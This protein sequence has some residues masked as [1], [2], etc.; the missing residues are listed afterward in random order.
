MRLPAFRRDR[1]RRSIFPFEDLFEDIFGGLEQNL[2]E[3]RFG[4]WGNTDI[5]EKEGKLHFETELPGMDKDDVKVQVRDGRLI[6]KGEIREEEN[7]EEED[8]L[9]R[10]RRY[11]KFQRVFPLPEEVEDP[12]QIKASFKNGVLNV[13][14]PL[15]NSL[16]GEETLDVHID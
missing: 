9:S 14:V 4:R 5:Y 8:Y 3:G 13:E 2:S 1:N 11:G 6:V 12:K 15:S 16:N 10:G 7:R